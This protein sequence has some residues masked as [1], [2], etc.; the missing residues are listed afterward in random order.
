MYCPYWIEER[1][2]PLRQQ[3]ALLHEA[4]RSISHE[5]LA[6]KEAPWLNKPASEKQLKK[7]G[8]YDKRLPEWARTARWT[9]RDASAAITYYQ[10][11]EV[12][13]HP[14]PLRKNRRTMDETLTRDH[15]G[16]GAPHRSPGRF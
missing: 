1:L 10:W 14:P 12:L 7:L 2:L 13:L 16:R 15:A 8:R 3:I 5:W 11:R 6:G 9:Q 4:T